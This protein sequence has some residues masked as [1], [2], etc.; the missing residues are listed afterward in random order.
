[1]VTS[2]VLP[3]PALGPLQ[4]RGLQRAAICWR[5][6]PSLPKIGSA[7]ITPLVHL[8]E[9]CLKISFTGLSK[10]TNATTLPDMAEKTPS[11]NSAPSQVHTYH[12]LCT[13]LLLTSTHDLKSLPRRNEPIQ[14]GALILAPPVDISRSEEVF[15]EDSQLQSANSVLL[16]VIPDRRAIM[17]RRED[18]FEKRMLLRCGRCKLVVGYT[19]DE[20]HFEVKGQERLVYLLPGGLISTAD[21]AEGKKVEIPPWAVES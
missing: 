11:S 15:S 13:T 6:L 16:N 14:D 9:V 7:G 4:A 1:M 3:H 17:I 10:P 21:M 8:H 2:E 18:G 5:C 20:A 19:L 12:C